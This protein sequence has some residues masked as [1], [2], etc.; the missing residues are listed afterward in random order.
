MT[1]FGFLRLLRAILSPQ[2]AVDPAAIERLGLLAV[3]IAQMYAVRPDLIGEEKCLQLSRLLHRA[4]PLSRD[5]FERRWRELAPER[6]LSCLGSLDKEPLAAASLGQIHRATL[7][8]GRQVVIKFAKREFHGEFLKDVRR[9]RRLLKLIL[10]FYPKLERLADP[11]GALE[12]VER[13][14]LTEMDFLA[15]IA[16]AKRLTHL[17]QG[18][19]A[20]LPHLRRLHFP[21]YLPDLS[22]PR[23][24][25][26]SFIEGRTLAEWL[27]AGNLPYEA[28]LDLFRLHGYFLFVRGEFHG[29]LHPGNIIWHQGEFW[30][31]DNAT[32]ETI[33]PTFARGLFDM[34]MLLGQGDLPRAGAQLAALSLKPLSDRQRRQFLDE[35][36]RLYLG[37]AGKTVSEVSLTTQMMR[38]IKMA[39]LNGLTFPRGAFP[40]IKS[41][42]YL[43][44]MVLRCAPQAVLLRDVARFQQ[45][46]RPA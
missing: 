29:D 10:F 31:L 24:L 7:R 45:D 34:L 22:H 5:D 8:D 20:S 19:A 36:A 23:F 39:V 32:I 44:G 37:F 15:E 11:A 33:P 16:G 21:E 1:T 4:T 42:M 27:A 38:T 13:Q 26:S 43:D 40:L 35:F 9:L 30:F 2:A 14:T 18:Q 28:L 46:F 6:L 17:V 41:L 25:V 3:K 12:A